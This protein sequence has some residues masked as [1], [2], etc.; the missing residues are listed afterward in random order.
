[1]KS[2]SLH[3][4][5]IPHVGA[6]PNLIGLDSPIVAV[7]WQAMFAKISGVELPWFIHLILGLSTWCIYL[8]DRIIDV[9]RAQQQVTT[10]R[11]RFTLHHIRKLIGLFIIISISNLTLILH[12]LPQKLLIT[13]C[14]T[15]SLI[16]IYYL[17]RLTRLK[18]I[19]TL[20]P[21]EV[22]CGMLFALGCAIA[23]HA[24]ATTSWINT[25]TWLISIILFGMVCSTS[26]I[27]ISLW[28]KE[29]DEI[30]ADPSIVTTHANFIP[31]LASTLTFLTAV[32]L[33]LSCFFHW[34]AF[35]SISLSAI[36]LRLALHHQNRISSINRRILADAVLLSPLIFMGF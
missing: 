28:E 3:D 22:M 4:S 1:M 35:L 33:I 7:C 11:H 12:Y 20:I 18:N 31:Y 26:C 30:A 19:I 8:V 27:L 16:A 6:W 15:L 2:P 14:I 29:G 34:Q 9:I 5:L 21:R 17:I 32:T 24:Y 25:P 13:G 10:S 23:P 36:L